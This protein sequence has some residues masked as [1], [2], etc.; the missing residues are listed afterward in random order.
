MD[1]LVAVVIMALVARGAAFA[2]SEGQALWW[3]GRHLYRLPLWLNKPLGLCGHCAV[4]IWGTTALWILHLLP[5]PLW[6]LPLY[7]LAAA[8]LQDLI[9]P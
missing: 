8:G 3:I 9:D 4:S 1:H 7:W 6:W 5:D 2:L